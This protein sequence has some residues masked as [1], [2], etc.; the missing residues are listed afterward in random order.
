MKKPKKRSSNKAIPILVMLFII[1]VVFY[2]GYEKNC[3]D[4]KLCFN[5]AAS[6]CNK[7]RVLIE[8]NETT[9]LYTVK[10]SEGDRCVIN[11]KIVDIKDSSPETDIFLG[12]DMDCKIPKEE[13]TF[14][15][16]SKTS[17]NIEYCSGPLKETMYQ[18]II[19]KMYSTIAQNLGDIILEI[20]SEIMK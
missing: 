10:G 12:K 11:V 14:D 13:I 5:K 1:F 16:I 6:K 8:N 18:V 9:F 7:A 19:Q 15:M 4:D 3:N 2:I 20:R 17:E